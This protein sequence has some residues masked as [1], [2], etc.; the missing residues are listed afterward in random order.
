MVIGFKNTLWDLLNFL[1]N[2]TDEMEESL[3]VFQNTKKL[4]ILFLLQLPFLII[5]ILLIS[6]IEEL[7]LVDTLENDVSKMFMRSPA[8]M[9]LLGVIAAPLLEELFFRAY[10]ILEYNF[11]YRIIHKIISL[12]SKEQASRFR[13][14]AEVN[15][16]KYF[17]IIVYLSTIIFAYVHISNYNLTT[18]III[19]S[20]ILVLPQF[21]TGLILAFIRVKHGLIWSMAFHSLHNCILITFSLIFMDQY[22]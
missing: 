13:Y 19:I 6:L 11:P 5:T 12:L 21:V 3:S 14:F 18:M 9:F 15:W 22:Q 8:T 20:P 16:R 7:G 4:V 1:K 17:K 2:P 10:L